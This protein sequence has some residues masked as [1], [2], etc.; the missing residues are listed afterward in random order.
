[1]AERMSHEN[2]VSQSSMGGTH[3][4]PRLHHMR[5]KPTADGHTVTHHS[6]MMSMPNSTHHFGHDEGP[7][8]LAHVAKHAGINR[9]E[10]PEPGGESDM[11]AG[12]EPEY[13]GA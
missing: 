9:G 5:I 10:G 3:E 13:S 11:M 2:P 12:E 6:S 7:E 4:N 8:L 1:M